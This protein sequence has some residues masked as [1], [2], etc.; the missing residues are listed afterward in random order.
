[1][2]VKRLLPLTEV[3]DVLG[4]SLQHVYNLVAA[5][6]ISTVDIGIG[7]AKTRIHEDELARY[8]ERNTVGRRAEKEVRLTAAISRHPAGKGL[9]AADPPPSS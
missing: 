1:M 5:R 8:I 3:A 4:S 9:R 7:R 6:R 2:A